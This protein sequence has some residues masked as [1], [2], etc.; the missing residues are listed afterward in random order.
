L[1]NAFAYL[2]GVQVHIIGMYMNTNIHT[3]MNLI[4]GIVYKEYMGNIQVI[5]GVIYGQCVGYYARSYMDRT[6]KFMECL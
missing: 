2:F 5:Y 1:E 3:Y 6:Y 4:F